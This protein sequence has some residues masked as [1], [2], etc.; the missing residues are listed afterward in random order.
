MGR[1]LAVVADLQRT[2]QCRSSP[3]RDSRNGDRL[4]VIFS[5]RPTSK[6]PDA[7]D[8][9]QAA[10]LAG[11]DEQCVPAPPIAEASMAVGQLYSSSGTRGTPGNLACCKRAGRGGPPLQSTRSALDQGAADSRLSPTLVGSSLLAVWRARSRPLARG[12]R[13]WMKCCT[14]RSLCVALPAVYAVYCQ[15]Q[16]RSSLRKPVGSR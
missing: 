10:E 5:G 16:R 8:S 6:L 7:P 1:N 11:I 14:Q 13:W 4:L 15:A 3:R 12:A 9:N 2:P